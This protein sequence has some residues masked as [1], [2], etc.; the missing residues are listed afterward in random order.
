[1]C[2][3]GE[4]IQ[5]PQ[6][7]IRSMLQAGATCG[8]CVGQPGCCPET[9]VVDGK[10]DMCIQGKTI[11]VS[12]NACKGILNAGGT[13]GPCPEEI[14]QLSEEIAEIGESTETSA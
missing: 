11:N 7:E 2:Y 8:T 10:I 4:N 5:V 1:M 9:P 13:C 6:S 14:E 12:T 3:E